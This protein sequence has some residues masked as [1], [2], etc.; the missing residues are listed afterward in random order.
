M[1]PRT[2]QEV[3]RQMREREVGAVLVVN[4]YSR[5]IGTICRVL[6]E[7]KDAA[8]LRWLR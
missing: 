4:D 7:G 2:I 8:K 6:A 5:L 3:A 1:G